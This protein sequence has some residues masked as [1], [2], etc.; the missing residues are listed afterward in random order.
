VLVFP[1]KESADSIGVSDSPKPFKTGGKNLVKIRHQ[2]GFTQE[3]TAEKTG[4]SIKYYQMLEAGSRSPTYSTLCKLRRA[5][6]TSWDD[7][8][9]GC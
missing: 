6:N 1:P 7:L 8:L 3:K 2:R 4:I 9:R 5:L